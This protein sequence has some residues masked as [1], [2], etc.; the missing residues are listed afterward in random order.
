MARL[1][2]SGSLMYSTYYGGSS[3]EDGSAIIVSASGDAYVAGS[4][5]SFDLP[6]A[7]GFQPENRGG[8]GD[9]FVLK[10]RPDGTAPVWA[11]YLGG[12]GED[13][14]HDLALD[15]ADHLLVVGSIASTDFR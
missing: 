6:S 4:T 7:T 3:F 2:S 1:D 8:F 14:T 9:G 11:S 13:H 5:G 10:I 15:S 12:N